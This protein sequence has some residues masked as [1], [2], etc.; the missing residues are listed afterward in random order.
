MIAQRPWHPVCSIGRIVKGEFMANERDR[1][2]NDMDTEGEGI[3]DA[4]RQG[5]SPG[6]RVGGRSEENIRGTADD[7]EDD[8][9]DDTDDLDDEEDEEEGSGNT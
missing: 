7:L 4:G 2:R 1:N 6:E 8:E 5:E 3:G 9:F